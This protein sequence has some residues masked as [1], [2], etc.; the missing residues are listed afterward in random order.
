MLG[1]SVEPV[2]QQGETQIALAVPQ[3]VDL[4]AADLSFGIRLTVEEHGHN[5]ERPH[6]RGDAVVKIE[7][8]QRSRA[9]RV[10]NRP[11]DEGDREVG[12]R[13]ERE[14]GHDEDAGTRGSSSGG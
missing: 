6:P 2:R 1:R 11:V 3:V 10:G 5:D 13:A 7:P 8:G 9:Q 4:Q 12:G 14:D